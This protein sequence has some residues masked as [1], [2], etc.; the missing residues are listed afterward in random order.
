MTEQEPNTAPEREGQPPAMEP[1]PAAPPGSAPATPPALAAPGKPRKTLWIVAGSIVSVLCLCALAVLAV[2][3]PTLVKSVIAVMQERDPVTAVL[4]SFM[5]KMVARDTQGA[6]A[7]F[8]PRAQRQVPVSE[9]AKM[10]QGNNYVLFDGY[11]QLEIDNLTL[12]AAV[13]TNPDVPQGTLANISGTV[14]YDGG[15]K[16]KLTATLEKVN[17]VW[18]IDRVDITVPPEKVKP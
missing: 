13:N 2:A 5:Q 7:L 17:G 12:T 14:S 6:Y 8:S 15:I 3:V 1:V 18:M 9:I 11:R 16:G 4:D 10:I